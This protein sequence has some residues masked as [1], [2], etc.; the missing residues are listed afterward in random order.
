MRLVATNLD[1]EQDFKSNYST[2][3]LLCTN[4]EPDSITRLLFHISSYGGSTLFQACNIEDR[5][6]MAGTHS[7][8]FR[9]VGEVDKEKMKV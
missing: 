7:R 1:E 8:A 5:K 4:L 6:S 2:H 3:H 9:V